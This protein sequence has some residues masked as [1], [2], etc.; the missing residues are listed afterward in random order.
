MEAHFAHTP[1]ALTVKPKDEAPTGPSPKRVK[2]ESV[3]PPAPPPGEEPPKAIEEPAAVLPPPRP[4]LVPRSCHT[5]VPKCHHRHPLK[6][7]SHGSEPLECDGACGLEIPPSAPRWS[8]FPC[9]FDVCELCMLSMHGGAAYLELLTAEEKRS[10]VAAA[11]AARAIAAATERAK[12]AE[13]KL[14]ALKPSAKGEAKP[15]A[16]R[17]AAEQRKA[18][19]VKLAGAEERCS[20]ATAEVAR[21]EKE[22]VERRQRSK[23]NLEKMYAAQ[24]ER[25]EAKA[26]IGADTAAHAAAVD[27]Q[28]AAADE[29]RRQLAAGRQQLAC[30]F[31]DPEAL[32]SLTSLEEVASLESVCHAGLGRIMERR[33]TLA[34]K[35][36]EG[37]AEL[38]LEVARLRGELTKALEA[39]PPRPT[40]GPELE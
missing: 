36:A 37:E 25:D 34:E 13:A 15:A 27:E 10:T 23:A 2:T 24:K 28:R 38:R 1:A 33:I 32:S 39:R 21:L 19:E 29:A 40:A 3:A 18:L 26:L 5:F 17:A 6:R 11:D 22:V 30:A 35:A 20:T 4:P 16:E 12:S 9:D 14:A 7:T 31:G 8:C